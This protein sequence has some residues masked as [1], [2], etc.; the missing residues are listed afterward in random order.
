M[1][2]RAKCRLSNF[3]NGIS[4]LFA[5]TRPGPSFMDASNARSSFSR[6][7]T[8]GARTMKLDCGVI[9]RLLEDLVSVRLVVWHRVHGMPQFGKDQIHSASG[10]ALITQRTVLGNRMPRVVGK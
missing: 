3:A 7:G 8:I 6:D 5:F 9:V 2:R 4:A 10:A 1:S